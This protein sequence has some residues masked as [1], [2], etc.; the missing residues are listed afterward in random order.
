MKE[1][2]AYLQHAYNQE[3]AA[4]KAR[5]LVSVLCS[6]RVYHDRK[7]PAVRLDVIVL[8]WPLLFL[9]YCVFIV[10]QSLH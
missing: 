3:K 10:V 7:K 8:V 9:T 6:C 4:E 2:A 1:K 5:E